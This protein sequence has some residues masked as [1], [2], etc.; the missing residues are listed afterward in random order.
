MSASLR[1]LASSLGLACLLLLLAA[2]S[3]HGQTG[4]GATLRGVVKDPGGAVVPGATVTLVSTT[5]GDQREAKSSGDGTYVFTSVDPGTYTV[6][7]AGQGFKISEVAVTLAPSETRGLDIEMEVGGAAEVVSVTAEEA[8]IKTE[9]GEKSETITAKQI[10]NLSIIGR[11]SLELLRILPGVV[12]PEQQALESTGFNQGGN[13]SASYTVNGIRGVNN[14][15]SIDGS[16]VVDIGS[17]NGTIIT[18]NNDMV[19]EVTV[20]TSNYAAE[21][22][23]SGVQIIATTKGGSRDFHGELYHY[24]RPRALAANDSSNTTVGAPRPQSS[25]HYPGGNIGGPILLP[26][27]DFNRE[28]DRLFF[29][30]GFEV[31]R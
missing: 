5:R 31:Q 15:V 18:P 12:G 2:P 26:G 8:P 29:W 13:A 9:T 25:F 4:G 19:S 22:G 14:N 28:R 16:R 24:M 27:T 7:V 3:A 11:S 30:L 1:R 20:K 23:S 21:Y 6:R 17:N 10:D